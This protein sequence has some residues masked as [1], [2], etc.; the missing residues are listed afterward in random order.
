MRQ[1]KRLRAV[2]D[3]VTAVM[4]S[5]VK[6]K[7]LDQAL[8]LPTEEELPAKGEPDS[9]RSGKTSLLTG[10]RQIHDFQ[11]ILSRIPERDAQDPQMDKGKIEIFA[12]CALR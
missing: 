7:R 12:I 9:W 2:D 8:Q 6:F 1:R 3:V 11:P 4:N 5:G 10:D